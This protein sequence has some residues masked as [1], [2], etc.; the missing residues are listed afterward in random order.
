MAQLLDGRL[1]ARESLLALK[2]RIGALSRPPG[3]AVVRVG[4][5]PAS[6]IYVR[7]KSR[8]AEKLGFFQ[9]EGLHLPAST[10]QQQLLDV[11][12][13]LNEDPQ[14]DGILVQLPLPASINAQLV[15][16]AIDPSKDVDGFHTMNAGRLAQGRRTDALM[17]ACTPKGAMRLLRSA[18]M[19]IRGAEAVVV[20]RSNIVG[21][22]MAWLLEQANATV[23]LC[24]SRTQNL[25]SHIKRADVV[26]AAVGRPELIPGA[27]VRPGAIVIDVGINRLDD[28]KVVGDVQFDVAVKRAAAIT[29]VPGGVGPMTIAMLMENTVISAEARQR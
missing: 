22:P 29:P 15:L 18:E 17:I 5:D 19:D 11:V 8:R 6:G 26:V 4:E 12:M 10:T 14:V 21:R 23:T 2:P 20:G 3:L 9:P 25:Q 13:R 24:H 16:D 27:W 7:R 28:G 1:L